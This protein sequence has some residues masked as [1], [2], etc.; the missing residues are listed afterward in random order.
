MNPQNDWDESS[1]QEL[2]PWSS[3]VDLMSA[4]ALVLFLAVTFFVINYN[5][6][7]TKLKERQAQLVVKEKQLQT[8]ILT[9]RQRTAS[10]EKSRASEASLTKEKEDIQRQLILLAEREKKLRTEK[11][12]LLGD[13]QALLAEKEKL[14]ADQEKLKK[15][16]QELTMMLGRQESLVSEQKQLAER[17]KQE[18]IRQQ[19]LA[20]QAQSSRQRCQERLESL[21]KQRKQVLSA[22]YK[23]FVIAQKNNRTRSAVG[24]DP[25][26]G[27]FRLGGEVLFAEGKDQLTPAGKQQLGVVMEALKKVVTQKHIVPLL[28]GIMIE[29]HT[30]QS[31]AEAANWKLAARRSL[32]ALRHLLSISGSQRSS[33][34]KLLFA[35]AYGQFRPIKRPDGSIDARRSRRI[36]IKILFKN[37]QQ[38]QGILRQLN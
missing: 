33:Y 27:R 30:S 9:L 15:E 5:R 29:G 8:S 10:L 26:S 13:R 7:S 21:L 18:T 34:A 38:I 16:K 25:K 4:F 22:I 1:E 6:A 11:E 23:S 12:K 20:S 36:E 35:A 24:F 17:Q 31:G 37:Q 2:D 3:I 14:I 19:N 32:A 28:S